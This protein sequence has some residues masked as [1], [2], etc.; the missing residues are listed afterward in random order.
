MICC[1]FMKKNIPVYSTDTRKGI[2]RDVEA[3]SVKKTNGT[4]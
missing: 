1:A 2:L 3:Q 4:C